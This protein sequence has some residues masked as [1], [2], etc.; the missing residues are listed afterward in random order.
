[1]NPFGYSEAVWRLFVKAPRAGV[2]QGPDV[3]TG[4]AG[5]PANRN[6]LTPAP[7]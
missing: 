2:L 7:A 6:R 3:R 4:T 5:T 1:M